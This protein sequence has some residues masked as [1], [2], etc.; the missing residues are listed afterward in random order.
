MLGAGGL[1][2]VFVAVFLQ[3]LAVFS[4]ERVGDAKEPL[5]V[6][7]EAEVSKGTEYPLRVKGTLLIEAEPSVVWEVVTDYEHLEGV[8]PRLIESRV[9]SRDEEKVVVLQRYKGLLLLSKSMEFANREVPLSRLEFWRMD[10]KS[11]VKGYWSLEKAE[12]NSTLLSME[13]SVRPRRFLPLWLIKGMLMN[14]VP[15][16]LISIR[17]RSLNRLNKNPS[18]EEPEVIF[19][20]EESES[21]TE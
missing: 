6:L 3:A 9:L 1:H 8:F 18:E 19:L 17:K 11:K 15:K 16:G 10:G 5:Q 2:S 7:V 4:L 20:G 21:D 12:G 13:V 14:H